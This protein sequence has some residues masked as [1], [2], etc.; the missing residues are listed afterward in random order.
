MAVLAHFFCGPTLSWSCGGSIAK[1][2]CSSIFLESYA[3]W[4]KMLVDSPSSCAKVAPHKIDFDLCLWVST[5]LNFGNTCVGPNGKMRESTCCI[6]IAAPLQT[7]KEGSGCCNG[8]RVGTNVGMYVPDAHCLIVL[9]V[10]CF[11]FCERLPPILGC[12][13]LW[14]FACRLLVFGFGILTG[15]DIDEWRLCCKWWQ[16][17]G[18]NTQCFIKYKKFGSFCFPH[19]L[20]MMFHMRF[21]DNILLNSQLHKNWLVLFSTLSHIRFLDNIVL[22]S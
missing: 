14:M 2:Q 18:R 4:L 17:T 7:Q 13:S 11:V 19:C 16:W 15:S 22:N 12:H 6:S 8:C 21:R 5:N 10:C 1:R 9:I 20:H 3:C